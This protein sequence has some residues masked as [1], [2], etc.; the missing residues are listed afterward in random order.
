MSPESAMRTCLLCTLLLAPAPLLFAQKKDRPK[1]QPKVI[2]ARPFGVAPDKAATV[3]LRGLRLD[4]AR[5]VRVAK[6]GIKLLKKGKA[7]VPQQTEASRVG[8]SQ[9]EAELTLP[10]DISGDSVEVTVVTPEGTAT[11]RIRIDR[12]APLAEKEPNDG[13]KQAQ[14]VKV[15]QT[16]EGVVSRAQDVDVF[17]VEAKAGDAIVVEVFAAR[18]GSALDSFLTVY[19]SEG[20]VV[21]TSDDIE[22]GTDSRVEWKARKAGA[23]LVSLTDAHDQ[24]GPLHP[25][26]MAIRAK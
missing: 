19:D 26:R 16:I 20:Q 15:G 9:V 3:V 6:G 1:E 22:G 11:H 13:F 12:T 23:Y 7:P 14:P 4:S 21:A 24:G 5:E 2:L 10:A 18:L 17:R 25:Y 8:D